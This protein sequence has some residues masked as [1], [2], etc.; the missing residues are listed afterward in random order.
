MKAAAGRARREARCCRRRT[1]PWIGSPASSVA[2][3]LSEASWF[4]KPS[5]SPYRPFVGQAGAEKSETARFL[6]RGSRADFKRAEVFR[7]GVFGWRLGLPRPTGATA[8]RSRRS[9]KSRCPLHFS[10]SGES[11]PAA[12]RSDRAGGSTATAPRS[13]SRA[14]G[15]A[16]FPSA[17]F[18]SVR[19]LWVADKSF[20]CAIGFKV[21]GMT[22]A[23]VGGPRP[24]SFTRG[25][26]SLAWLA[27][28]FMFCCHMLSR[29]PGRARRL[30]V[31]EKKA[32]THT[33]VV[34]ICDPNRGN[35]H[36]DPRARPDHRA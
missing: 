22:E 29:S 9:S 31:L 30:C 4:S 11:T 34:R 16:V 3:G 2:S 26:L 24:A 28:M 6:G 19:S 25:N 32:P 21:S 5:R 27:L 15:R 33:R 35:S 18:G 7:S 36:E 17:V 23:L 13:P 8:R 20:S 12:C 10:R 1:C 14:R